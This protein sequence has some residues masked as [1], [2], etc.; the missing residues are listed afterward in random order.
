GVCVQDLLQGHFTV[1]LVVERDEDR[2]QAA[3]CVRP[4]DL[5]ALAVGR[6]GSDRVSDGSVATAVADRAPSNASQ[7]GVELRVAD[8]PEAPLESLSDPHGRQTLRRVAA[9]LF[10]VVGDE[11]IDEGALV[12]I[13]VAA[14]D[15]VVSQGMGLVERP[16]L[17]GGDQLNLADQT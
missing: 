8:G 6:G 10:E 17:K 1:Q 14:T 5:E 13:E 9:M 3:A 7:A 16:G 2:A 12:G 11:P 4:E 15:E